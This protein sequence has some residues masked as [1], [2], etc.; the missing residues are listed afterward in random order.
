LNNKKGDEMQIKGLLESFEK[1]ALKFDKAEY[2]NINEY[3]HAKGVLESLGNFLVDAC[4][5]QEKPILQEQLVRIYDQLNKDFF[6]SVLAGY[7]IYLKTF[8]R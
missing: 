1:T 6:R 2:Q 4:L 8:H 3:F 5:D 7:I